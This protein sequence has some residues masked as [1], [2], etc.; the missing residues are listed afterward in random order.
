MVLRFTGGDFTDLLNEQDRFILLVYF[1]GQE[2]DNS[3]GSYLTIL[4]TEHPLFLR[5]DHKII[6]ET[7]SGVTY[8]ETYHH[9]SYDMI[10]HFGFNYDELWDE[11]NQIHRPLIVAVNKGWIVTSSFGQCYCSETYIDIIHSI[12]PELFVPPSVSES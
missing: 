9:E 1:T 12:Y 4:P 7:F 8:V 3:T 5:C 6:M 2:K 10:N 11:E